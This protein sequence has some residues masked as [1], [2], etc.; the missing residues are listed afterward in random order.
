MDDPYE[1]YEAKYEFLIT[2]QILIFSKTWKPCPK[3]SYVCLYFIEKVFEKHTEWN[4][5][6]EDE[7]TVHFLTHQCFYLFG[8]YQNRFNKLHCFERFF[9]LSVSIIR[10]DSILI[11]KTLSLFTRHPI[12]SFK[13][14]FGLNNIWKSR[15]FYATR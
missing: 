12:F 10:A 4:K 1:S 13:N 5:L 7:R 15:K 6:D 8:S 11:I 14:E 9:L 3:P 2:S